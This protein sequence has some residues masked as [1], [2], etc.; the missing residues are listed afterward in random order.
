[1]GADFL[2][3]SGNG[4]VLV[5][6]V[7]MAGTGVDDAQGVTAG[8][9]IKIHRLDHGIIGLS[10]VNRHHT[11]YGGG[12]LVHETAGLAKEHVLGV[13][14]D[15]GNFRLG[16]P[17]VKEQ[18]VQNGANEDLIG[19]GGAEAGAGQHRGFHVGVKATDRATQ[20]HEAGGHAPNQGGGGVHLGGHRGQAIQRH[21]GHGVALG[22][23]ADDAG[24]R[25]TDG[26]DHVQIYGSGQDPAMLMV[27]V[28]TADLRAAGGGEVTLRGGAKSGGEAGIQS[29]AL[30][31][32]QIKSRCGHKCT[33]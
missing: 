12:G 6:Q 19:G 5:G 1:M 16:H 13:L 3:F 32:G 28:V 21:G 24:I 26:G 9:E 11:A 25:H 14:A 23:N 20:L 10:K 15:H 8:G 7:R 4:G 29:R 31:T 2:Q 30:G 33:S 17:A 22:E 18:V 27:G